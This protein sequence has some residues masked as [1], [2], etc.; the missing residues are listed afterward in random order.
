[1]TLYVETSDFEEKEEFEKIPPLTEGQEVKKEK[2]ETKQSFTEPPP[3][4]TEASL[5]KTLEEKGIGRPSTYSPIITTILDK[6]YIDRVQKQ[7]VP[8]DLGKIVNNLLVEHFPDIMNE[9]FTANIEVEFD[10]IAEGE[11]E[12]KN[13]MFW[14]SLDISSSIWCERSSWASFS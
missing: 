10:K 11:E 12:W 2:I 3:R 9:E 7:L 13:L 6:G 4:Y 8:T 14:I 1:M 5:V